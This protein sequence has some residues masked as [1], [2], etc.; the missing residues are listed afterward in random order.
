MFWWNYLQ[1]Q[2]QQNLIM[3]LLGQQ[4]ILLNT[5]R[6]QLAGGG[7]QTSALAFGGEFPPLVEQQLQN[8]MNGTNWTSTP[9]LNTARRDPGGVGTLNSCLVLVE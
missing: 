1:Q 2:V 9:S 8:L 6:Y 4:L 3:E 7:T 5:G